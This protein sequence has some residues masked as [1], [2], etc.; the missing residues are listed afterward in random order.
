MHASCT[1][2]VATK[3]FFIV[4]K[5]SCSRCFVGHCQSITDQGT[6]NTSGGSYQI[7]KSSNSLCGRRGL[8]ETVTAQTPGA[9]IRPES[10]APAHVTCMEQMSAWYA[11]ERHQSPAMRHF[12]AGLLHRH[13]PQPSHDALWHWR[14]PMKKTGPARPLF[15]PD[16]STHRFSNHALLMTQ[17][18]DRPK[19][20]P[21]EFTTP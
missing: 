17:L 5:D 10:R 20:K 7:H 11:R 3:G 18:P 12:V 19:A 16:R 4:Q 13:V 9:R 6:A 14:Y 2:L 21:P 15:M 8:G 1:P